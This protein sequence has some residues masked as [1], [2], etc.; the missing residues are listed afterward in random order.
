MKSIESLSEEELS[1]LLCY[2]NGVTLYYSLIEAIS[3]ADEVIY[4]GTTL[5]T[6][7]THIEDIR[8]GKLRYE[9][10]KLMSGTHSAQAFV[11]AHTAEI[12]HSTIQETALACTS[13]LEKETDVIRSNILNI[14]RRVKKLS[15]STIEI[16]EETTTTSNHIIDT[17][18]AIDVDKLR[19]DT[20]D[21]TK[22]LD[23]IKDSLKS[24]ITELERLFRG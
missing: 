14:Q 4:N 6:L 22:E 18:K 11:E 19:T 3:D 24:T 16:C 15:N 10:Y 21:I 20:T 2:T 5:S 8:K 17:L 7:T 13:T 9:M 1:D 23:P 12:M